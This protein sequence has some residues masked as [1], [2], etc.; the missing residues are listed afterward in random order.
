MLYLISYITISVKVFVRCWCWCVW[1]ILIFSWRWCGQKS[2]KLDITPAWSWP[3]PGAWLKILPQDKHLWHNQ[4]MNVPN[5]TV[6]TVPVHRPGFHSFNYCSIFGRIL[7]CDTEFWFGSNSVYAMWCLSCW[8]LS[9]RW[10]G[11]VSRSACQ[12]RPKIKE[13]GTTH[14]KFSLKFSGYRRYGKRFS[15][16]PTT[17]YSWSVLEYQDKT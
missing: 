5:R 2:Q 4:S 13:S 11:C 9:L 16:H 6:R 15:F 14:W 8:C 1:Y 12:Q 17:E 7:I 10:Y 3:P